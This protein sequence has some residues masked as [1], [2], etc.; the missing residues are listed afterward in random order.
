MRIRDL[1]MSAIMAGLSFLLVIAGLYIWHLPYVD[2]SKREV[3][4]W[5]PVEDFA[6]LQL[7]DIKSP[8]VLSEAVNRPLFRSSRKPFDPAQAVIA[9]TAPEIVP[10]PPPPDFSQLAV[11]GI[12]MNGN[13]KLALITTPEA[14]EGN[15][16][17]VG[18]DVMGWKIVEVGANGTTLSASGQTRE[19]KLY[20]DNKPN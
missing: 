14:P 19:L 18:A 3:A 2:I 7:A 4:I 12:V 16:L 9:A 1:Q 17:A 5:K 15:W 11:R 13:N 20:V 10:A 6:S 8:P